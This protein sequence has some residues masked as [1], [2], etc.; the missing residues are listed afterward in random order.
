MHRQ[1][2]IGVL[3]IATSGGCWLATIAVAVVII[4]KRDEVSP[5]AVIEGLLR[6]VSATV[7]VAGAILYRTAAVSR[8]R[9]EHGYLAAQRDARPARVTSIASH[10]VSQKLAPKDR[11]DS[12]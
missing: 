9:F 5:L 1:R 4:F 6:A 2:R 8:S 3:V 10:M 7:T 11:V 12:N